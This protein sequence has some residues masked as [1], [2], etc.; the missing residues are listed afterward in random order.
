[1]RL[2]MILGMVPGLVLMACSSDPT[3]TDEY[4]TLEAA[5][6]A[7]EQELSAVAAE[8]DLL[9]AQQATADERFEK[10]SAT[11]DAIGE[12]VSDP[13]AFGTEDEVLDMLSQY[14][15]PGATTHDLAYGEI[16]TI[17]GWRN[18][19][20]GGRVNAVTTEWHNWVCE[21]GSQGGSLWTWEGTN[22]V[23][24][25]FELIGVSIA[26]YNDEGLGTGN[27]VMWPYPDEYVWEEFGATP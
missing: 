18:T 10:S 25:P 26:G 1:M 20:F 3:S 8:R 19:L 2:V 11:I 15:A 6:T 7:A 9:L 24:E 14:F 13:S 16:E 27:T 23:G 4:Q 21:D 17:A 22:A 12:I 5:L